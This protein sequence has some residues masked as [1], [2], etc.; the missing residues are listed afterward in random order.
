MDNVTQFSKIKYLLHGDLTDGEINELYNHPKVKAFVSFISWTP[1]ISMS[2]AST[3]FRT[4]SMVFWPA[5]GKVSMF[6][7]I[8]SR[9]ESDPKFRFSM[10]WQ[11]EL[12]EINRKRRKVYF[13]S[14]I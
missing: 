5:F 4:E 10:F 2:K 3:I 12:I 14:N 6:Q 1:M 7:V 11:N 13:K 9:V 8:M